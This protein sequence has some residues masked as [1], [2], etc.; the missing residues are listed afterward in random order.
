LSQEN[1][2]ED[3]SLVQEPL[4]Y[5]AIAKKWTGAARA[6]HETHT[7]TLR[8]VTFNTWFEDLRWE[9][10]H[11]ALLAILKKCDADVIVLQKVIMRLLDKILATEWIQDQYQYVRSGFQLD[12]EPIH[13]LILLS[14][15]PIVNAQLYSLPT[16]MGRGLLVAKMQIN[17]EAFSFATVHLESND[18]ADRRAEQLRKI[19]VAL[20][21]SPNVVLAGDFNFCSSQHE[22]NDRLNPQYLDTWGYLRPNESGFTQD[23]K[24][25]QMLF[26]AR[27]QTR[28]VRI[29]RVLLRQSSNRTWEPNFIQ[30]L[31]TEAISSDE[32]KVFPSDH[33]GLLT[34]FVHT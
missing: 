32:P 33:F 17:S 21:N 25:N 18:N 14:R 28:Q 10:R 26:Q 2:I 15:Q 6:G 20:N 23:T 8:V 7:S 3:T 9:L 34:E 4:G 29:D 13:G 16:T 1:Q 30:L 5:D 31:G 11:T 22:E 24:A 19:F 12:R 27:G